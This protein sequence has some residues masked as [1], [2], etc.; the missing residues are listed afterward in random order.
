[1]V[2]SILQIYLFYSILLHIMRLHIMCALEFKVQFLLYDNNIPYT[3]QMGHAGGQ[4]FGN[5]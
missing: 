2:L 1:M 4:T 3:D 5:V